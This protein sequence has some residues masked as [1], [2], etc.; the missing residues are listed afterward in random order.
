MATGVG[1]WPP[2]WADLFHRQ[3]AETAQLDNAGLLLV[4]SGQRIQSIVQRGDLQGAIISFGDG[5]IE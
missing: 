3:A 5:F 2:G 1:S 4:E